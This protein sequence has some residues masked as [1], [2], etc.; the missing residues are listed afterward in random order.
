MWGR[1][2]NLVNSA[3]CSISIR[4]LF[5]PRKGGQQRKSEHRL[6]LAGGVAQLMLRNAPEAQRWADMIVIPVSDNER[7][8]YHQGVDR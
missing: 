5:T 8:I 3:G 6:L 1:S 4:E 7:I 2:G